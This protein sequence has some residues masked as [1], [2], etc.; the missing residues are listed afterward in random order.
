MKRFILPLLLLTTATAL[1]Q[2]T[3]NKLTFQKGQVLEVTT[4]MN[5]NTQSMMGEMP[6]SI[7]M[8]DHFAVGDM[9]SSS[10]GL[11]KTPKKVKI[12]MTLMGQE[13]NLDSDKPQD[14]DGPMGKPV[15]EIMKRSQG[16][17]IDPQG[18]I[19]AVSGDEKKKD[20]A[21]DGEMMSMMLPGM[22]AGAQVTVG[23]PSLFKILPD[24]AIMVGKT[25]T[26]SLGE[27]GNT[28][29]TVYTV[30]EITATEIIL[31]FTGDATTKGTQSAMGMS[32][33]VSSSTKMSGT[34][35]ID[36]ASGLLKQKTITANASTNMMMNGQDISST[37]K[38]TTVINVKP[39]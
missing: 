18:T 33:D 12:E 8:V 4:N 11:T 38:I 30:K 13:Y 37:S 10:I 19:T 7:V 21:A 39:L 29:K 32:M 20:G 6:A 1:A 28:S 26:E 17:T 9:T 35:L 24:E 36:K 15:K 22:P 16:F 23:L 3:N 14:L 5:M 27:A 34:V 2:K 31:D 25:W